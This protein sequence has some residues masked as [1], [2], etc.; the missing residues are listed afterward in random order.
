MTEIT[1]LS[2]ESY[3]TGTKY[4]T[5]ST[6]PI[7]IPPHFCYITNL[8]V[9]LVVALA[10]IFPTGIEA[11]GKESSKAY[12]N[13]GECKKTCCAWCKRRGQPKM[14]VLFLFKCHVQVW[15]L[16]ST[17]TQRPIV[18]RLGGSV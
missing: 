15:K 8:I 17:L 7:P 14:S 11:C 4:I 2:S 9:I 12:K 13:V 10:Q 16:E 18:S 3:Y 5:I 1:A 6:H